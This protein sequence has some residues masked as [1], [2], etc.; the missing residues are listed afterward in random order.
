MA[1]KSAPLKVSP[2]VGRPR[3]FDMDNALDGFVRVFRERGF[4]A[5]SIGDLSTETGLTAG[6]LYKAFADKRGIFVAALDR[7]IAQRV[8]GLDTQLASKTSGRDKVRTVLSFYADVSHGAEGKR[9][10]LVI[11]SALTLSTL[12]EDIAGTVKKSMQRVETLLRTLLKQAQTDGSVRAELNVE[13]T[14]RCLFA[15]AEGFRVIGK[16]GQSRADMESSVDEAMR[17]LD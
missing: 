15:M 14:A 13:T 3:E 7:Y 16:L 12:D 1:T 5:T 8:T 10:C 17:L 6:S 4:H 9:G 11:S 2:G